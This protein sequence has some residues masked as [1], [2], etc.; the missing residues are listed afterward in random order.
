MTVLD[1][2]PIIGCVTV[3][4][5]PHEFFY[6]AMTGVTRQIDNL[7]SR[8]QDRY[9]A[10][11]DEAWRLHIE[12][13]CG[14]MAVA[15]H[16]GRYWS[17]TLGNL[18]AADVGAGMQVRTGGMDHHK[19]ILHP[20]D[21]DA[22]VFVLVTGH[23][24]VLTLRGWIYGR[25]GKAERWWRDPTGSRPAFFVPQSALQPMQRYEP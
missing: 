17:G 11:Q 22:D 9:G 12:G 25:D 20:S 6:A 1:V 19:L 16:L 24:P 4:L 8:R 3:T 7:R 14:E 15:K 2:A 21:P 13:A 18:K 10:T 5:D 23:A